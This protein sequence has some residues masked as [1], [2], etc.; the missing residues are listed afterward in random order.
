MLSFFHKYSMNEDINF[1]KTD[2]EGS[3]L[4]E[5][6]ENYPNSIIHVKSNGE[7]NVY[8]GSDRITDNYNLGVDEN[9]I[10]NNVGGMTSG[11]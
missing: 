6:Q 5:I 8:I 1:I 10:T 7:D 9:R 11:I 4:Q 3:K 2:K